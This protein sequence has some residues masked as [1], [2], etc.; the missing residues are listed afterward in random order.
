MG[1]SYTRTRHNSLSLHTQTISMIKMD[2]IW[3]VLLFFITVIM[4]KEGIAIL[5]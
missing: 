2:P 3:V 5:S 1:V 4:I